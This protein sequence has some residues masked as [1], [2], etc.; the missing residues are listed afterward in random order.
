M[1]RNLLEREI[2]ALL[3]SA[4][5]HSGLSGKTFSDAE[6]K[7]FPAG[8][9]YG[10]VKENSFLRQKDLRTRQKFNGKELFYPD[11]AQVD[12]LG[13]NGDWLLVSGNASYKEKG[14]EF[15]YSEKNVTVKV[16]GWIKRDWV[17]IKQ[18]GQPRTIGFEFDIHFGFIEEIAANEGLTIPPDKTVLTTHKNDTDGFIVKLDGPRFEAATK[19]FSVEDSGLKELEKTIKNLKTFTAELQNGCQSG[20]AQ[21]VAGIDGNA[22]VFR[23]SKMESSL[24]G[25]PMVKLPVNKKFSSNCSVWAS[26]QATV[27]IPLSKVAPLVELIKKSE[28]KASGIALTGDSSQRMGLRSEAVYRAK[29]QVDKLHKEITTKIPKIKLSNGKEVDAAI[30][31]ESLRGF[32]ILLVSYLWTSELPYHFTEPNPRDYE[33]FAKAFLPINVKAP[34]PDIFDKLLN[35]DEKLFFREHF[36]KDETVRVNLYRLVKPGAVKADGKNKLFPKGRI[37]LGRDSVHAR[38]ELEFGVI[39]TWNDLIEHTLNSSHNSWGNRLIVPLSKQ[40]GLNKTSPNV[41]LELR[42]VGF[43]AMFDYDWKRFMLNVFNL[44][45][46][47]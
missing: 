34:F 18:T 14:I 44:I 24:A 6:V 27:A 36:A 11:K 21:K 15:V 28:G 23:Y 41:A 20:T 4:D 3:E 39:P 30:F 9:F 47:I 25:F 43:R 33:P 26:P 38:Q 42:R 16:K 31:S 29:F 35:D 19:P 12:I 10:F 8:L 46:N 5:F 17:N 22:R 45:K 37:E 7:M 1:E 13:E 40:I 2:N 32:L